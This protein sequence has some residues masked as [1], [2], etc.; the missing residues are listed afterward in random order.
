MVILTGNIWTLATTRDW[1]VVP[2]NIGWKK[3][4]GR[5]IMG[6]G[7]AAQA[8]HRWPWLPRAWGEHCQ[9][10]GRDTPLLCVPVQPRSAKRGDSLVNL[11]APAGLLLAPTKKLNVEE[12]WRSWQ[13]PSDPDL[14]KATLDKIN[15][16]AE[17]P[18]QLLN[19]LHPDMRILVPMLGCGKGGLA[20]DLILP[21]MEYHLQ[22]P[23]CHIVRRET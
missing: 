11:G 5:G 4:S 19:R 13:A 18:E 20:E 15:S 9:G 2:T 23:A 6:A 10:Y 7:L 12:P 3:I 8:A 17:R 1:V 21:L 22:A 16:I 14:I